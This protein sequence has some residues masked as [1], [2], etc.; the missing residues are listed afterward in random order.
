MKYP[1]KNE[2]GHT[3]SYFELVHQN[4]LQTSL[5]TS[6]AITISRLMSGEPCIQDKLLCTLR[7]QYCFRVNSYQQRHNSLCVTPYEQLLLTGIP[8]D[9]T[10]IL[11]AYLEYESLHPVT[12]TLI[13]KK[14]NSFTSLAAA[15]IIDRRWVWSIG[16]M[17]LIRE[18]RYTRSR[19]YSATRFTTNPTLTGLGSN[20][21]L[22]NERLE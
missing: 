4:N 16:R 18:N 7:P 3:S 21:G 19:C 22:R 5:Y 17:I 12:E 14:L 2:N 1:R 13:S 15:K 20:Q 11:Y 8:T 10:I 6:K 9:K